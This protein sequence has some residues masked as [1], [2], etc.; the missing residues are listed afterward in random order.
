[1][2]T[3]TVNITDEVDAGI[4][5]AFFYIH[6]QSPQNA[7]AWLQGLYE[8]IGT[9]EKMPE[10]CPCIREQGAFDEQVRN[11]IYHSHRII[12]TVNEDASI[13]EVHAFRHAAQDD[14][15]PKQR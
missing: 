2:K 1:M 15:P 12:F 4:R 6:E 3:Y 8:A 5:D 13:V 7:K 14:I 9:L 10:R 11:L